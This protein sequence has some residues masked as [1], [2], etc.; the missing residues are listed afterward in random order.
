M[1]IPTGHLPVRTPDTPNDCL[2][3]EISGPLRFG[4]NTVFS[5]FYKAPGTGGMQGADVVIESNAA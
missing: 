1:G 5:A 3:P 4:T 2:A